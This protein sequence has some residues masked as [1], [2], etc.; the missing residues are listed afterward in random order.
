MNLNSLSG[1]N[2]AAKKAERKR[3]W[4]RFIVDYSVALSDQGRIDDSA[5]RPA[6]APP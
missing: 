1:R 4:Q 3:E 5:K 2:A 6:K